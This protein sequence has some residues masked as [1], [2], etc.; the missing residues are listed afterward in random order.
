MTTHLTAETIIAFA[1]GEL[2]P[3]QRLQV[4]EHLAQCARCRADVD[5]TSDFE[6]RVRIASLARDP[7][8]PGPDPTLDA[9]LAQTAA[10]LLARPRPRVLSPW[11]R[12][13]SLLLVAALLA[14]VVS[15]VFWPGAATWSAQ[16]QFTPGAVV[17][18]DPTRTWHLELALPRPTYLWLLRRDADGRLEQLLPSTNPVLA[19]VEGP[20]PWPAGAAVRVPRDPLLDFAADWGGDEVTLLVVAT[21]V[22]MVGAVGA[23]ALQTLSAATTVAA[24]RDAL[25]ARG[26]DV[27]VLT[28]R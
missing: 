24:L 9:R 28:A 26:D 27:L 3:D 10:T 23:Q 18:G 11:L 25:R 21:P 5:R 7:G 2:T 20:Q 4:R 22:R 16:I 19:D 13:G 12:A 1:S 6:W 8:G 17:R 15:G 14:L